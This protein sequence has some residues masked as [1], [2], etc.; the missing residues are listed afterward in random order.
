M[1]LKIK[2]KINDKQKR[3]VRVIVKYKNGNFST[4]TGFFINK[5]GTLLTC[6][7]VIFGSILREIRNNKVLSS[8]NAENEHAKI[9]NYFDDVIQIIEIELFNGEKLTAKLLKFNEIYDIA[10]LKIEG[11]IKTPFF[12]IDIKYTTKYD[13][14]VFFCGFQ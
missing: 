5:E 2:N 14:P 12:N 11:K 10:S 7:H 6:F 4:G 13:E 8:Y 3:L 9:Q 1:F